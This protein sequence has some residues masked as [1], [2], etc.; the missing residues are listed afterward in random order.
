M[1]P[2][3]L[4]A[5]LR[6]DDALVRGAWEE[7]RE[8]FQEALAARESPAA[9]E[10]LGT[11]A[12]WLDRADLVF[13]SR[14]KA[15][16]LYLAGGDPTGAAR[17]A[18]WLAWDY[19]AFRGE[20]AVANGWLRRARRLLDGQPP[21]PERAWLEVREGA[22]CL[23]ED[24]DPERAQ[25]L[26]AE[27]TRIAQET[28]SADLEM[29]GRAVQGMALVALG[30]V[31]EGMRNLD[32][33]SAAVIAGE[34]KDRVAIGLSGC[35]LIAACER[36]RDYD[37][38][39]QWVHRLKQFCAK[40]GLRPLF[41]VCRTQ[42]ASICLWRGTWPEAETEL[43]AARDEL[44]ASRPAMVGDA[45]VRLAELRRRQ[46]R[47]AEAA[48]LIDE[49]STHGAGLLERAELAL[50]CNDPGAAVDRAEEFLRRVPVS[51]RTDR[52]AG[53]EI[54]VRASSCLGNYHAAETSLSELRELV[55]VLGTLPL[56]AA[57]SYAAGCIALG[58]E[59]ADTARKC[60]EDAVDLYIR[61]GAPFELGRARIELARALALLGR[62]EAA[63]REAQ[64]AEALLSELK[65]DLET[66]R[67]H[68]F[69]QVLKNSE[70]THPGTAVQPDANPLTRRE[71]EIL[72]LVAEGLNNPTIAARLFVSEHT[73]HRHVANVLNKLDV[74]TRAAAVAQ[75]T[76]RRLLE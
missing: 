66:A 63:V 69:L 16:R 46:G 21:S 71:I 44:A 53:L 75:A 68:G 49:A 70:Q 15:Y 8:A 34:L 35:Y 76:R 23:L 9:L 43:C 28:G 37:R 19:W 45:L 38:A 54:L 5:C 27:G 3:K 40:C 47:I 29:L 31:A 6:G 41:A 56:R 50:D 22:L 33:V 52:A 13:D 25:S 59:K 60:F 42:Y 26:A 55:A 51:N 10:G 7:A 14:E 58:Q 11:A 20:S 74:S 61:C 62:N 32:E 65:A 18:V 72:S 39:I 24:G 1:P 36:V 12:W 64:R 73:V 57:A 17:V 2:L 67:A 30:K 4:S 48:A